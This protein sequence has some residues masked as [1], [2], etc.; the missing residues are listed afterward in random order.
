VVIIALIAG[1]TLKGVAGALIAV[2]VA[3]AIQII[4]QHTLFEPAIKKH[5]NSNESGILVAGKDQDDI[6][7]VARQ[8]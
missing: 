3:G 1:G 4:V 7:V 2:P 6:P 8:D 5:T